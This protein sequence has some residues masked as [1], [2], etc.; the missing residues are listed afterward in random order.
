MEC[1]KEITNWGDNT[2][3]HSYLLNGGGRMI[4][5]RPTGTKQWQRMSKPKSF[6]K[7]RRRF[8]KL[9]IPEEFK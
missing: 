6:S 7:S 9:D 5:Y 1:L 2:P 4:A 8:V 3:N